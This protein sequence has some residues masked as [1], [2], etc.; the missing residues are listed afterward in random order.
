MPEPS[1]TQIE[2]RRVVAKY[3][4]VS[5]DAYREGYLG[6]FTY[7]KHREFYLDLGLDIDPNE[8]EGSTKDRFT[9]ILGESPPDVKAR[10]LRGILERYPVG[11]S[12]IRTQ[13]IFDEIQ[14]YICRLEGVEGVTAPSPTITSHVV[15]RAI[16][17]AETLIRTTGATSGVDRIHTALHG[18]LRAV[19]DDAGI[20]HS[21]NATL[22]RLFGLLRAEHDAFSDLGARS[23]DINTILRSF[24][25]VLDALNPLRN[26]A[27]VAHPNDDLL[28]EPEA[29]LVINA[30]RSVLHYL[31]AR[32]SSTGS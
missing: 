23:Q 4:G 11:S 30:A 7:R 26:R 17:D 31:D 22:N 14:G 28:D 13:D 24:N 15:D 32:I 8:Y 18:Y 10:I 29:M 1:L 2:I 25:A 3:I 6:D 5:T 21:E 16:S 19:C 20:P 12:E 9:Q 27:S